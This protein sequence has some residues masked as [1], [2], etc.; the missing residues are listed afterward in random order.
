[1]TEILSANLSDCDEIIL[2]QKLAYQVEATL[3]Q[4]WNI[5]PL[6]QTVEHLRSEFTNL[7]ILKAIKDGKIIGSVRAQ[8]IDD[9]CHIGRLIVHPDFQEQG[10]GS[11][12]LQKIEQVYPQTKTFELFTG[13][14]SENNIRFYQC[15]DYKIS[16][17]KL[18]SEKL[19]LVYLRKSS[20]A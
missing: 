2:L 11:A 8:L 19:T 18:L 20:T 13:S 17:T 3:Y 4:D 5:P 15:K 12:L 14:K 1:M 10:T 9:V 7:V 6:T 16:H